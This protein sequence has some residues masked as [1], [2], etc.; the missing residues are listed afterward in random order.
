MIEHTPRLVDVNNI[1]LL[2]DALELLRDDPNEFREEFGDYFVA[3]YTW[4]FR[5]SAVISVTADNS[6][7]LDKVC[8][9]IQTIGTY[10]QGGQNYASE[11]A[12][13]G[14]I[15]R[16]NYLNI[17]VDELI[18]DGGEPRKNH[19]STVSAIKSV[20]D[21]LSAFSANVQNTTKDDYVQLKVC[22]ERFREI[23]AA[24]SK[25]PELLPVPQ[26]HFNAILEMNR[27]IFRTHFYYNALMSIPPAKLFDGTARHDEWSNEYQNLLNST[28]LKI[29]YICENKHRVGVRGR[30]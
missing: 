28:R 8:G 3:G 20:A 27:A 30:L 26:S 13:I 15:A 19:I 22:F 5:F 18:I 6:S 12:D 1:K 7:V 14:Q 24:T 25:I 21:A 16:K 10:A 29:G 17:E 11:I 23:P 4:G 2:P 9:Q